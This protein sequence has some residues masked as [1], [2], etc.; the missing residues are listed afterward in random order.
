MM[1]N[2]LSKVL[3]E[4]NC[5]EKRENET[6]TAHMF[7]VTH[8]VNIFSK[9]GLE[10]AAHELNHSRTSTTN[11]HYLKIEERDLLNDEE[12]RLFNQEIDEVLFGH[13]FETKIMKKKKIELLIK[14]KD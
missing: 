7:R 3:K 5:F 12:E 11:Q 10:M 4:S 9:F 14:K 13:N 6:I 8:A 1:S 2:K